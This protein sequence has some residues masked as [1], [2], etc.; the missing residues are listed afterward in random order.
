MVVDEKPA[1]VV[2]RFLAGVGYIC[3]VRRRCDWSKVAQDVV[4]RGQ[5]HGPYDIPG[6]MGMWGSGISTVVERFIPEIPIWGWL[7]G[8]RVT[9]Y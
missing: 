2:G 1:M 5:R 7:A 6:T 8:M 9:P 4:T 3:R